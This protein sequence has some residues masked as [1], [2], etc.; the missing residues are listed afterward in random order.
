MEE[1]K[2]CP[3]CKKPESKIT[4]GVLGSAG[5]ISVKAGS[6]VACASGC[7]HIYSGGPGRNVVEIGGVKYTVDTN[8]IRYR[9]NEFQA[10]AP[11]VNLA[12]RLED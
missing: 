2:S 7:G 9:C 1:G 8:G 11:L 6:I 10:D 5:G 3:V 4:V 12:W